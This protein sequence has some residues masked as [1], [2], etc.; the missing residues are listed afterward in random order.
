MIIVGTYE[1]WERA[2]LLRGL[3]GPYALADGSGYQFCDENGIAAAIFKT[4]Y[5][6]R[7]SIVDAAKEST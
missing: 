3:D 6:S 5:P 1:N 2:C 7:G 4:Q